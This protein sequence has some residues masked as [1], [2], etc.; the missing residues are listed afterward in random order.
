MNFDDFGDIV[1]V[2][3]SSIDPELPSLYQRVLMYGRS[4]QSPVQAWPALKSAL[5]MHEGPECLSAAFA[6]AMHLCPKR[7]FLFGC[8]LGA[9]ADSAQRSAGALGHSARNFLAGFRKSCTICH[10]QLSDVASGF[11]YAGCLRGLLLELL[12]C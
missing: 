4:A 2:L 1:G 9:V 8:D 3:P 5:L 11:L 10:D 12:K 7:A 6:F